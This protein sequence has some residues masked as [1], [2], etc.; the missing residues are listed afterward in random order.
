M[1]VWCKQARA[2]AHAINMPLLSA[3]VK[4][5]D[6]LKDDEKE[7]LRPSCRQSRLPPQCGRSGRRAEEEQIPG[8]FNLP[9]SA[10]FMGSYVYLNVIH[11]QMCFLGDGVWDCGLN[12]S[13]LCF[14]R[15]TSCLV[16]PTRRS[17]MWLL[18]E[19]RLGVCCTW[20]NSNLKAVRGL[21]PR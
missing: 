13:P 4:L 10:D 19:N 1:R 18:L 6:H 21:R 2:R 12:W 5:F 17:F 14:L 15:L 9:V 11:S 20:E 8:G 16:S 3:G 7:S